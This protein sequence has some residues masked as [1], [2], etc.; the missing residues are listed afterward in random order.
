MR[1]RSALYDGAHDALIDQALLDLVHD[2]LGAAKSR[3]RTFSRSYRRYLLKG[4]ARCIYCGYP[5][6][7]ETSASGYSYYREKR[8]ARGHSVCPANGKAIRCDTIDGQLDAVVRSLVLEPS[9]RERIIEK[10]TTVAE[11]DGIVK[12][13]KQVEG[14]LR[15][16]ARAYVD[17]LVD[18]GEYDLQRRTLQDALA[19][20]VMPETDAALDAGQILETLGLVWGTATVEE[21]HRL[22]SGMMEA[23]YVGLAASRAIVG[24]QPKPPFRVLFESLRTQ[25][26][27]GVTV[28]PA[29]G[30]ERATGPGHRP[31]PDFG[32]VETGESRTPDLADA[33]LRSGH[34][35]GLRELL[36][37]GSSE[38][39]TLGLNGD[40]GL[41]LA[42]FLDQLTA[43]GET[44]QLMR[45]AL[46]GSGDHP[47]RSSRAR[48]R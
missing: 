41:L 37:V 30:P 21:R 39:P 36:A 15:R 32:M 1:H 44:A 9:W 10:L 7:S 16:L 14:R 4:I 45:R 3:N 17:G 28:F 33:I 31:E 34:S 11:R 19:V 8:S 27:S 46:D 25:P 26:G 20:L 42:R 12:Q 43:L 2:R 5:L 24:V 29:G 38:D 18:D 40:P 48:S 22:L 35:D 47:D 23:L 6:W 13:R